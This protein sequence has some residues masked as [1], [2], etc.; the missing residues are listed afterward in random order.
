MNWHGFQFFPV[1]IL[2]GAML[3]WNPNLKT[4]WK[5]AIGFVFILYFVMTILS[6]F[7]IL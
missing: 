4:P 1:V 2:C 5:I 3:A 7:N 6:V